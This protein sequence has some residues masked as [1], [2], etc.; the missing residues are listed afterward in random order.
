MI[1]PILYIAGKPGLYRLV[2]SGK[3]NF[4]VESIDPSH[5]R[6]SAFA[7]DRITSLA[8]VSIYSD[9]DD[10]PLWKIFKSMGE[11]ENSK[12][13]SLD[14]KKC[15][16]QQLKDYFGEILPDYDRERVHNSDIK[17]VIQWYNLLIL[18]GITDFEKEFAPQDQQET[19]TKEEEKQ[20]NVKE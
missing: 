17:K 3:M 15:T 11:K 9:Q 8:D 13:C 5:K 1:N 6:I 16:G 18:S 19:E 4:I 2:K 7:H 10:V 12:E 20:E 14:Y